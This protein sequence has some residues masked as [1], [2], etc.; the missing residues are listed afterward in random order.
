[1]GV[2]EAY[3]RYKYRSLWVRLGHLLVAAVGLC[4]LALIGYAV[5][6]RPEPSFNMAALL[7][8]DE[9]HFLTEGMPCLVGGDSVRYLV[10]FAPTSGRVSKV[11]IVG[12]SLILAG[13]F[14]EMRYHS[15]YRPFDWRGKR[16]LLLS[17]GTLSLGK[18]TLSYRAFQN[19]KNKIQ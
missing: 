14:D 7:R 9:R 11:D 8:M 5:S 10:G 19:E 1:M 6:L 12:D 18:D 16:T 4:A 17:E 15:A 13:L 3:Q 2:I